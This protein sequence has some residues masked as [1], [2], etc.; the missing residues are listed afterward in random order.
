MAHIGALTEVFD[1]SERV[2]M[3]FYMSKDTSDRLD[4]VVE[5]LRTSGSKAKRVNRVSVIRTILERE[6]ATLKL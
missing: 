3:S 1:S 6:L 2:Q 4:A 5:T